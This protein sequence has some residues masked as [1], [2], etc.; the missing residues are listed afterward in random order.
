MRTIKFRGKRLDNQNWT[1][2][3]LVPVTTNGKTQPHI[4]SEIRG[5]SVQGFPIDPDTVGQFTGLYD[6]KGNEVWEGDIVRYR[7]TDERYKK[8][9]RIKTLLI[10]YEDS[11]A[12]FMA[13]DIYWKTLWREKVEVIGNIHDNPEILKKDSD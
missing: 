9:P 6:N 3:S 1:F 12:R 11:S 5:G 4:V 2:G 8:N 13:G 7:L 10:H